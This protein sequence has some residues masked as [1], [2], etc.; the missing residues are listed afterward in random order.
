MD[1][2]TAMAT[3]PESGRWAWS[4]ALPADIESSTR[5]ASLIIVR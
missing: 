1:S 5:A 3:V 2:R 4:A